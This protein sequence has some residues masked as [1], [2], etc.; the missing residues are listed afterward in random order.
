MNLIEEIKKLKKQRHAVILAHYY[1]ESEI[2]DIADFLGDSLALAVAAQKCTQDVILFAGVHFMAETAK[3]L[4]PTKTVV[5]PSMNAGCSLADSCPAPEFEKFLKNYPDYEVVSYINCTAATKALSTVICT[6]SNAEKVI[7][8]ITKD[9]KIVF[10]PDYNLG[11]FLIKKTGRDMVLWKGTCVVHITFSLKEIQKL[12][13]ESPQAE[14][15]AHPECEETVLSVADFIGSTTKLI[16]YATESSHKKFIVVTEPGVIH[17]MKKINPDNEYIP[18]P[19]DSGCA[20][21]LCPYMKENTLE[22]VYLALRDLKPEIT[23]EPDLIESSRKPL[24]RMLEISGAGTL[25]S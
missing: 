3:I 2:Q 11:R 21:N 8:T 25:P 24:Q 20:C 14:I 1:Q 13:L 17:Q 10:A 5:I 9:K 7:N 6:S 12:K 16:H 15:I 19:N 23:L 22:K 4:N 18:A